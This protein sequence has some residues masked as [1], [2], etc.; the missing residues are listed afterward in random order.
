VTPTPY[1][2]LNGILL[3]FV[4]ATQSVLG[5]TLVAACL[6]GSFA[7]G[8]FD[9]HS[10]VDFVVVVEEELSVWQVQALQGMHERLYH[11]PC[12]WAQHLEGSYFPRPVLKSCARVGEPLWYLEH[13]HDS[14]TRSNHCN[15]AV[16]RWVVREH[17]V[18]LA[19]ADPA[20]LVDPISPAMLRQ[21][22]AATIRDWG[23]EI[24]AEPDRFSN[25]FYQ[26][27]IVLSY[28]RMLHDLETGRIQSKRAGATWAQATLD[29]TWVGLIDRAWGGRPNP[30]ASIRQ[31]ADP[32]DFRLT[33]AFV[34][35]V[36][37]QATAR[38]GLAA[39]D[40]R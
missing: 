36:I 13:G 15:T 16:V 14:L 37:K 28:C 27:F 11:L 9:Q 8:G 23:R 22:I 25:R 24:L 12:P 10:D 5:D 20:W 3:E 38:G 6:Q 7:T 34:E 32:D 29:A 18:A 40:H 39:T 35:Y 1:A 4:K 31:P 33:L 30:A 17:G 2:D 26:S 21:E 19:G